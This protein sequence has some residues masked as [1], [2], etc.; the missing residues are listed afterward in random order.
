MRA[1]LALSALLP[2]ARGQLGDDSPFE[3]RS[4]SGLAG[5]IDLGQN[6]G[7]EDKLLF[8]RNGST[9][10][11]PLLVF[12]DLDATGTLY[13]STDQGLSW[14]IQPIQAFPCSDPNQAPSPLVPRS[15]SYTVGLVMNNVT[16]NDRLIVIGGEADENNVYYSDDCGVTWMCY[17]GEQ[18]WDPRG[19]SHP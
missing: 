17:D 11:P 10:A 13:V 4:F 12:P 15:T 2:V 1:A 3:L 18:I 6:F 7:A 9:A 14:T 19:E 5:A 16:S 8:C